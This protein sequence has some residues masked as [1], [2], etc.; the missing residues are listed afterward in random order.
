MSDYAVP[1]A[2]FVVATLLTLPL[3]FANVGGSAADDLS[4][5]NPAR[6]EVTRAER[7]LHFRAIF[8][9]ATPPADTLRYALSVEKRGANTSTSRQGGVFTP[10]AGRADTLSTVEVGVEPGDTVVARLE[11]TGPAGLV[12]EA[13]FRDTIR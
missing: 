10:T 1:F 4:V 8:E 11:V 3:V 12:A 7:A 2:S 9:A 13:D 5:K 6:I